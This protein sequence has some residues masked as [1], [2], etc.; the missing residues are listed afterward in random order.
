MCRSGVSA[1]G[2][3]SDN[4]S[5]CHGDNLGSGPRQSQQSAGVCGKEHKRVSHCSDPPGELLFQERPW[6]VSTA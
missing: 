4:T 3:H 6:P 2:C 5:S 1:T